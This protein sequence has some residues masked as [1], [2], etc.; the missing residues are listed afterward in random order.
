MKNSNEYKITNKTWEVPEFE[1]TEFFKKRNKSCV[2]IPVINEGERIRNQL[3]KMSYLSRI[4]DIIVA[5]GGSTDNSTP[6]SFLKSVSVRTFLKIKGKPGLSSQMR[7]AIAYALQEKY[8]NL[9]FIDGNDKDEVEKIPVFIN[10][11]DKGYDY[12][13]AS[14]YIK[15]GKSINTPKLRDFLIKHIHAPLISFSAAYKYTDTTNGFRGYSRK[16]L[17]DT[18][19]QPLRSVFVKYNLHYYLAI[20]AAK[21]KYRIVEVPVI[22]KYPAKGKTPTKISFFKGNFTVFKDLIFSCIGYYEPKRRKK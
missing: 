14:R 11:L 10:F 4:C 16:F 2:C 5:D 3:K 20:M 13:Q 6:Q 8:E 19:V 17:T 22:R 12:V 1:Y 9:V 7:M 18:K 15:G 21:L